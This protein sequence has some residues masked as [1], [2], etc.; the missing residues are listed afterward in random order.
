MGF[1]EIIKRSWK[2]TWRYKALWV[3]GLFAGVTGASSGG[4]SSGGGSDFGSP[5]SGSKGGLPSGF[6]SQKAMAIF[7]RMLP[8]IVVATV[9]LVV[10]GL[11]WW[12]LSV[13]ARG[14][15]VHAVNAIEEGAPFTLGA[16]WNA[17]FGRFW[18]LFGL[19]L[20][21]SL[22]VLIVGLVMAAAILIP[23]VA[24]LLR[25]G[26]PGVG[27]AVPICGSLAIGVP[28]LLILGVVLGLLHELA[29]RFVMLYGMGT[30]EAIRESWRAFRGRMKDTFLMWLI[31]LGLN[32]AAG[33]VLAI[34]LVIIL[35]MVIIPA[36]IAGA[37][38]RWALFA[39]VLGV[40]FFVA[41][42]GAV[43]L[44]KRE[45]GERNF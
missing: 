11:V 33:L 43:L 36:V 27:A 29:L 14:G 1:G 26:T 16:A 24:P 10:I 42:V 8:V 6:D 38:G 21:L 23:L 20:L 34:P 7:E 18:S 22:P 2:I 9:G 45:A 12:I 41:M 30:V 35:I 40:L 19:G 32:V 25:G 44:G 15:L 13:A 28:L 39:A 17:G 4:G 5:G 3:L 37:A 31:N